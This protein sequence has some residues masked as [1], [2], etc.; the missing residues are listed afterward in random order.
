MAVWTQRDLLI[1]GYTYPT[2]SGKYRESACTGAIDRATGDM[3][4]IHPLPKRYLDRDQRFKN[5]Q[6]ISVRTTE[7]SDGRPESLKLDVGTIKPGARI[8]PE[9]A[10]ERVRWLE[11]CGHM[12]QSV[13]D[14][15]D[16]WEADRTSLG[17]IKPAE[18]LGVELRPRP[19]AE[20]DAWL[21]K[22]AALAVGVQ[23]EM[24]EGFKPLDW[25]EVEFLVA[26]RCDDPRCTGHK[27]G[28]KTWGLHELYRAL[29]AKG[30]PEYEQKTLDKMMKDL[31]AVHREIYFFL[32][33]FRSRM[34]QF[35]LMDSYSPLKSRLRQKS[36]F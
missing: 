6:W 26:W 3:V 12:C 5:F 8:E 14:L 9:D 19:L 35:G 7:S 34:F 28:I 16:R 31:D 13:E 20:R 36:L 15:R 2:Y 33:N 30:D 22:E 27:M 23:E 1:L 24:F 21:E 17:I 32:G 18:I 4:R 25:P 29:K 10:A 11:D